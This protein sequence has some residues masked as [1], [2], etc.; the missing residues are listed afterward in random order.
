MP[1]ILSPLQQMNAELER[2]RDNL[3][4]AP[5]TEAY[6]A[7]LQAIADKQ[8]EINKFKGLSK[9]A[10]NSADSFKQAAGAINQVSSAL[11][12]IDDPTARIMGTIGQA[13]ATIAMA[14]S[15]ALAKDKTNKNNIWYFIATAAAMVTSMATTISAIHS[16]TGYAEGGIV[17]G[18]T[19]SGDQI[20]ATLNA[21]EVVLTKAMTNNLASSIQESERGGGSYKPSYISGEQIWLV[22]NHYTKRTGKG[23]VATWR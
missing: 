7:G 1:Q 16:A 19:Y 15:E 13:I 2:L 23:E 4:Y 11:A 21:G 20:P 17:Q 10:K 9:D 18:N 5:N 22:L 8:E 12:G 3:E 6:L 14:Y